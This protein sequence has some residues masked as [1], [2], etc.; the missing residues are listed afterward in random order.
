VLEMPC[1]IYHLEH[2]KGSGWTPDGE[3][4]LRRRIAESGLTWLDQATVHIWTTYMQWLNRP[5]IFNA[6]DWGFG[7]AAL[8]ETSLQPVADTA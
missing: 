7:D 3:A 2:E 5:M 1:C 6:A 4:Q 8:V